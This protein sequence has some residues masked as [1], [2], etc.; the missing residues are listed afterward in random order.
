MLLSEKLKA[1]TKHNHQVLENKLLIQ[2]KLITNKHE[3]ASLLAIFYSFFGGL[4]LAINKHQVVDFLPDYPDRRKTTAIAN[5]L[6]K[7]EMK[8]PTFASG[9]NLPKLNTSLQVIGALYVIEGST[10]GGRMIIKMLKQQINFLNV[11]ELSFFYGYGD[12][13][14]NMWKNFKIYIDKPLKLHEEDI[15]IKSANDTF[16]QFTNWFISTRL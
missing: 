15:V 14:E 11:N 1:N 8:L 9:N 5:D 12:Q 10:L 4:E 7:L 3:Y 2:L 13:T 16:H 6:I